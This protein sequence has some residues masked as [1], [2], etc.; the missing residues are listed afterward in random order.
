MLADVFLGG[1]FSGMVGAFAMTPVA[2]VASRQPNGPAAFASFL[3]GFWL[4][5]PGTLGLV[6][7]TSL[8]DGDST[9]LT[10]LITTIASM[11]AI[12]LGILA[13]AAVGSRLSGRE[14]V[15]VI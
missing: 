4:L 6:G 10:T 11:V 13:G 15:T 5:V 8:L 2:Y 9:G 12:V 3:P 1:V 7:V 14:S